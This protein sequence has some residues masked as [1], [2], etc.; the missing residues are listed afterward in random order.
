MLNSWEK[1]VVMRSCRQL[2][3]LLSTVLIA[4]SVAIAAA[5]VLSAELL[6]EPSRFTPPDASAYSRMTPDPPRPWPAVR[7][8]PT[9]MFSSNDRSRWATVRALVDEG[10]YVIGRR[11]YPD[12]HNPRHYQDSG[13][14]TEPAFRS[15]DIVLHPDTG[16]FY[17][18]KPPL[19]AT[20]V[21]AEYWLLKQLFGWDIVRDRWLVIPTI[22]L[23]IN[24]VPWG[25]FLVLLSRWLSQLDDHGL[26]A[27]TTL[28]VAALGT[29]LLTFT[30]T[31]NNHLPAACCV[32]ASLYPILQALQ[33]NRDLSRWGYIA[34]GWFAGWAFTFELPAL[35]WMVGLAA[36]LLWRR[37]RAF[38]CYWL[39]AA[40]V[41]ITA[42]FMVNYIAL[43]MLLPPYS[44][45]GGIWYNF[46]GSHWAKW[47]TPAAKGID[48]NQEPT[49]VY[50]FHLLFGHHG[51]FSLTPIWLVALWGLLRS[52]VAAGRE[53]R[54]LL[55]R[56]LPGCGWTPALLALMI[57]MVSIVVFVFYLTRT[58]SY[59]YGGFTSGP[60]WL[61]WLIPLWLVG[62]P[63]AAQSLA[64]SR[65]GRFVL[66]LLLAVSV[67]S[68]AYPAANPWRHPWLLN[69]LEFCYILH[70]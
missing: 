49:H 41:P 59:N 1:A 47:G 36:P 9:P 29:F 18:S 23:T 6:Y 55:C 66:A 24:V 35:A 68:A 15:L 57:L 45:F 27:A 64:I 42:Y 43:G 34:S 4:T 11:H 50:A 7:P 19:F 61:F 39:P 12:P 54:T 28:T 30:G 46:E 10:T 31:L 26:G 32:F 38:L 62:L 63:A 25:V 44:Q 60:R 20:L 22:L 48:F 65:W 17:S 69:L 53:L 58:Q 3:E 21:A 70:Y 67:F 37:P 40:A 16:E 2:W 33:Q 51:W 13:I 56:Q 52:S 8:D 14:I 5:K